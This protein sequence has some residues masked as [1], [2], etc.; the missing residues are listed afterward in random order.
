M[1]T[2]T[3]FVETDAFPQTRGTHNISSGGAV[4]VSYDDE[5]E[6]FISRVA[7][8]V[9]NDLESRRLMW[10]AKLTAGGMR[11]DDQLYY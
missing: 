1:T 9:G 7:W 6:S 10:Q 3:N 5:V 4:T 11:L 2:Q 8:L